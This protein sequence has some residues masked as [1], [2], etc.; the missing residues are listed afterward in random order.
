MKRKQMNFAQKYRVAGYIL[1][2]KMELAATLKGK[3]YADAAKFVS[4]A[5]GIDYEMSAAQLGSISKEVDFDWE[6]PAKGFVVSL[7]ALQEKHDALEARI[8][9]LES[10]LEQAT[11]PKAE[12]PNVSIFEKQ[13]L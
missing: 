8:A 2:H 11:A 7:K 1:D 10:I 3:S 12:L 13:A 9:E 4:K 5:S 6:R